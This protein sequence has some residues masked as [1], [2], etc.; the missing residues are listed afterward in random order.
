MKSYFLLHS[1]AAAISDTIPTNIA[2]AIASNLRMNWDL[3]VFHFSPARYLDP[4]LPFVRAL[5]LWVYSRILGYHRIPLLTTNLAS[6]ILI[7]STGAPE[8]F[9]QLIHVAS[10]LVLASHFSHQRFWLPSTI[11]HTWTNK[12]I[13]VSNS[14]LEGLFWNQFL[15]AVSARFS[16]IHLLHSGHRAGCVIL[17]LWKNRCSPLVQIKGTSHCLHVT[18][19]SCSGP[20]ATVSVCCCDATSSVGT[21]SIGIWVCQ[22]SRRE[23]IRPFRLVR[24]GV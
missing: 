13:A 16:R 9:L 6:M 12:N 19:M 11:L 2:T 22:W 3:F 15:L 14:G 20:S 17:F 24:S 23:K 1:F 7:R 18:V 4:I 5:E 8:D 10:F 21:S